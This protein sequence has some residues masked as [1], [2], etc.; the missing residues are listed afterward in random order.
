MERIPYPS[1][2]TNE[3]CKLI[4]PWIPPPKLGG[5][6]REVDIREVINGILY[7]NRTGCS[8]RMLPHEF[9]PWGTVHYYY[10][11]FRLEGVWPRIHDCLREQ[12]R[13]KVGRKPTPS[14]A[15]LDSQTVKTEK[16]GS[17]AT[18]PVRRSKDANDPDVHRG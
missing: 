11:R 4:E 18:M 16:G 14:A 15:I 3:Q 2:L 8:W 10:R 7:L 9:P 13:Q 12:V 6:P 1:D 17:V 5:R